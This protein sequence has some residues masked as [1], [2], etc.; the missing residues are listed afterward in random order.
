MADG[1]RLA[2]NIAIVN[3]PVNILSHYGPIILP[4]KKFEGF[5]STWVSDCWW[6]MVNL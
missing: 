5:C 1:L 3:K 6:V 4:G 2:A